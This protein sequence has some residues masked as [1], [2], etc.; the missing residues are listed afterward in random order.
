M[1]RSRRKPTQ[2]ANG[3]RVAARR[4]PAARQR[5][6]TISFQEAA[7]LL[8]MRERTLR[9]HLKRTDARCLVWIGKRSRLDYKG[10]FKWCRS[11]GFESADARI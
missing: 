4:V 9:A 7:E 3:R 6:L 10:F 2:G 11:L 1:V 8:G 5:P